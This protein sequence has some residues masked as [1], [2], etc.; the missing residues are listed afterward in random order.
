MSTAIWPPISAGEP[1]LADSIAATTARELDWLLSNLQDTLAELK[2][3]LLA[4]AALLAPTEPGTTLALSSHRSESLKGFITRVGA[5]ILKADISLRLRGVTAP[6]GSSPAVANPGGRPGLRVTLAPEG[7]HVPTLVLP[8]LTATRTLINGAL[9]VID[10]TRWA[11]DARNANFLAG[12]LRL[13]HEQIVEATAALKGQTWAEEAAWGWWSG[14]DGGEGSRVG[15]GSKTHSLSSTASGATP[16]E[17]F[18]PPLPANLAWALSVEQAALVLNVR[19]LEPAGYGV[20]ITPPEE[21]RRWVQQSEKTADATTTTTAVGSGTAL[22]IRPATAIGASTTGGPGS[23]TPGSFPGNQS[24]GGVSGGSQLTVPFAPTPHHQQHHHLLPPPSPSLSGLSLRDRLNNAFGGF[25]LSLG[26]SPAN[27]ASRPGT[28][29]PA[30]NG[31][32]PHDIESFGVFRFRGQTV[33]VRERV[34]VESPDP[35]LMAAWAKLG[36]LQR[37]CAG[38]RRALAVVMGEEEED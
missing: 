37:R 2:D 27:S 5:R 22:P 14:G 12:Q 36:A 4:C 24:G 18:S 35:S 34:R 15:G 25:S 6:P 38:A 11:G 10:A 20:P 16:P 19:V 7:P 31:A 3:G 30:G 8:Q 17:A 13:L 29:N 33:R 28:P 26:G 23:F 21:L 32:L 9:D 1:L